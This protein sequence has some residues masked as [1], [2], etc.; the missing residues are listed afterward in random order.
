MSTP[1]FEC[2]LPPLTCT[3][4]RAGMEMKPRTRDRRGAQ[5]ERCGEQFSAY[6]RRTKRLSPFVL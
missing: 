1:W 2:L 4:S 6:A 3:A 5:K